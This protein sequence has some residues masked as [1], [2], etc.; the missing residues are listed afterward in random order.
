MV[1]KFFPFC[2]PTA[3]MTGHIPPICPYVRIL[4]VMLHDPAQERDFLHQR[5]G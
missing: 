4:L 1:F 2:Y 3:A 5:D